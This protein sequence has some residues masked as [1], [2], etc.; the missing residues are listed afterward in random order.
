MSVLSDIIDDTFPGSGN[1]SV[2]L[3]SDIFILFDRPM[4]QGELQINFFIEGPDTDQW[5]G[6]GL[7]EL[8]DPANVSQGDLDNFLKSPGYRGIVQGDFTFKYIDPSDSTMEVDPNVVTNYR[9]KLIFSPKQALYPLTS[10][11]IN[12]TDTS[13]LATPAVTHTGHYTISFETGSGSITEL[14]STISS[15]I[16]SS[17]ATPSTITSQ[18][19][20]ALQ[21]L[22]STPKDYSIDNS[23]DLS[24]IVL[25]FN[26]D[27]DSSTITD[28]SVVI[29]AS[30]VCDHPSLAA[31]AKGNIAKQ[32]IVS[33]KTLTI[34]I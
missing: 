12:L 1:A 26:K 11:T 5:I 30:A 4:N 6:P 9:T 23:S 22:S 33:G 19:L 31:S 21:L 25:T 18:A 27:L 15:S 20:G 7:A 13:D 28:E 16:L 17:G 8:R 32:L 10:Y 34:K 29:E 3:G 24:E 14:P 2:P